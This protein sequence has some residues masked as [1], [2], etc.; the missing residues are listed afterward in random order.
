MKNFS[1]SEPKN[2]FFG[3]N[4]SDKVAD[5][6][7]TMSSEVKKGTVLVLTDKGMGASGIPFKIEEKVKSGGFST[8][9]CDAVPQEPY[10]EDV[11]ALAASLGNKGLQ[12]IIAIGGGSVLDTAKLLAVL[13]KL[14]GTIA[15]LMDTGVPGAGLPCV[16]IPTTAGTGSESTPNAIVALKAK[17]LKVGI[18]S[19]FFMPDYVILDPALTR[20][21]PQKLTASTGVDALCHVLECYTC[22]K[23]NPISDMVALEGIKLIA[24]SIRKAYH[25][26][27]DLEARTDM[28]LGSYLGGMAIA[29]SGTTAVHALSYPLGG[30]YRIPH[31]VANAILLAPVMTFNKDSIEEKLGNVARITGVDAGGSDSDAASAFLEHLKGIIEEIKIPARLSDLG[32]KPN[33]IPELAESAFQ[34]KRLL[35]N[36]PKEMSKDD[37]IQIYEEIV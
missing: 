34:V 28:L 23:A 7:N 27:D 8:E 13:L 5:L 4:E 11:E 1:F 19:P 26:G 14:G 12:C 22:K 29:S 30:T 20:T 6:L 31:G 10:S 15:T 3:L 33:A 16:M 32:I 2:V 17:K 24:R 25:D 9:F 21:L 18:V 36:N 35:D 37:I